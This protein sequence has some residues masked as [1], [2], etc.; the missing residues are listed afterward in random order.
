[1]IPEAT[2][3]NKLENSEETNNFVAKHNFQTKNEEFKYTGKKQSQFLTKNDQHETQHEIHC[4]E[5]PLSS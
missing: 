4:F 3:G 5:T 1:M 2:Y